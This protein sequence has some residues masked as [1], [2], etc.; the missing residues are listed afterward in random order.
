M[1]AIPQQVLVSIAVSNR[2]SLEAIEEIYSGINLAC[3]QYKVDL[4]GGDTNSS[5]SGWFFQLQPSDRLQVKI[6][7]TV[8]KLNYKIL[9]V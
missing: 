4:A 5:A 8:I 7:F 3:S 6:S 2:F 9:F 1:N